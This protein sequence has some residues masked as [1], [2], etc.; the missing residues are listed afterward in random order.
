MNA[1]RQ[2]QQQ[3]NG[4]RQRNHRAA[5]SCRDLLQHTPSIH[6]NTNPEDD[7][8]SEP[9][10]VFVC[11]ALRSGNRHHGHLRNAKFLGKGRTKEQFALYLGV[12]PYVVKSEKVSWIVGEVYEVDKQTL[13][14]L[15][16][17]E[18]CPSWQFREWV[19]VIMDDGQ[20]IKTMM[21]FARERRKL[22]VLSGDCNTI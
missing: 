4:S 9:L 10:H 22:L 2:K 20:E 3:S 19:D 16:L 17:V 1:L 5:G 21:Y 15:D 6:I 8:S 14:R 11:G 7:E 18:Q 12:L 13:R